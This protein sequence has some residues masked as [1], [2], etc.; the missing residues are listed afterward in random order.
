LVIVATGGGYRVIAGKFSED[1]S[2]SKLPRGTLLGISRQFGGWV[3][4]DV[5]LDEAI[6]R[7]TDTDDHL[8]RR[9]QRSSGAEQVGLYIAYGTRVRDLAPHRPEVCYPGSGWVIADRVDGQVTLEN[10]T[11]LPYEIHIFERGGLGTG[12]TAVLSYYLVNG[13]FSRDVSMVRSMAWKFK[14]EARYVA[15][16]QVTSDARRSIDQ[17]RNIVHEFAEVSGPT[18][19]NF[20]EKAYL[21]L[22][23]KRSNQEDQRS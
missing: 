7:A 21:D 11:E 23:T 8:N 18:I 20:L 2:F 3:G 6:V 16:I 22:E 14:T 15:Q 19:A 12:R 5:E 4:V 1:V 13:R 17:A 9:Y 10:G